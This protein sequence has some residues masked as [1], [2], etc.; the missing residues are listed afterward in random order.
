VRLSSVRSCLVVAALS[1]LLLP[2]ASAGAERPGVAVN[3]HAAILTSRNDGRMMASS[4]AVGPAFDQG[5]TP[6]AFSP[7]TLWGDQ[8]CTADK[9]FYWCSL[10]WSF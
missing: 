7:S 4:R 1:L 3:R 6:D 9:R 5:T 2:L 10:S 8:I